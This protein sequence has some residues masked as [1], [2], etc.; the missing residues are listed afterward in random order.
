[1]RAM[2]LSSLSAATL[3]LAAACHSST[4]APTA[5]EVSIEDGQLILSES[6]R[7]ETDSDALADG[8]TEALDAI[9]AFLESHSGISAVRVEGHADEHGTEDHNLDLSRRRA[10]VVADYLIAHGATQ[11]ISADGLGASRRVCTDAN[12]E[13]DARNRRV[14]FFVTEE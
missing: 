2:R 12:E 5:I 3:V 8:S 1:M 10:Q 7:F 6:I 11:T 14:D 13:C 4:S 9:A